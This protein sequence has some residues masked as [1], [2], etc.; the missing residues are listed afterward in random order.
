M[1]SEFMCKSKFSYLLEWRIAK[2]G[3]QDSFNVTVNYLHH[4]DSL[5]A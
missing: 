1:T 2:I 3:K 4:I 5:E